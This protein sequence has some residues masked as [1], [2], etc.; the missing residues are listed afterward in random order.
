MT[1]GPRDHGEPALPPLRRLRSWLGLAPDPRLRRPHVPRLRP[2]R[3]AWPAAA[4]DARAAVAAHVP[5]G[6]Y[7]RARL[8]RYETALPVP[9]SRLPLLV[10]LS[11]CEVRATLLPAAPTA[12]DGAAG[13]AALEHLDGPSS[14]REWAQIH[15]RIAGLEQ[16]ADAARKRVE[17]LADRLSAD[18]AR[19]AIVPAPEDQIPAE[20]LGRPAVRPPD[21][22]YLLTAV[23]LAM[24]AAEAWAIAVP[25]LVVAGAYPPALSGPKA[26]ESALLL[27][28]SLGAAV[29]LLALASVV[30]AALEALARDATRLD[31]RRLLGFAT[32]SGVGAALAAAWAASVTAPRSGIPP[33]S[34]ALL[35][36]AIPVGAAFA[37]RRAQ[38]EHAARAGERV[39]ALAW[40]RE[41]AAALADR[42][43]RLEELAWA[44]AAAGAAQ[45]RLARARRRSREL[46]R[47]ADAAVRLLEGAA[48]RERREGL[49][50]AQ[51]LLGALER[52]RYEYLRC[53]ALARAAEAPA[54]A[55]VPE[56]GASA[57]ERSAAGRVAV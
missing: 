27:V 23:A 1:D 14:V 18:V 35:L 10:E 26:L 16:E 7:L 11:G 48:R 25:V 29:G 54:R 15:A 53:A 39:V 57:A 37:V 49:R 56:V 21:L 43:R 6:D 8:A 45:R 55:A 2:I 47:R 17:G 38:R 9:R 5:L 50:L 31:R 34:H 40:D 22:L 3:R 36:L 13:A 51:S 24:V 44:E 12:H 41:R 32:V 33:A 20:A 28:F 4:L 19:G 46:A 42:A 30:L 52:D